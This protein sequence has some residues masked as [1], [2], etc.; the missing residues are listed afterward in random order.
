M[1]ENY[2]YRS[3]VFSNTEAWN[4][5]NLL[6][7]NTFIKEFEDS[8]QIFSYILQYWSTLRTQLFCEKF[9]MVACEIGRKAHDTS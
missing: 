3:S 5:V 7:T 1:L 8:D 2:M 6:Q 4:H 9:F